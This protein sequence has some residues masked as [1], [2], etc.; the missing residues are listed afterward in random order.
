MAYRETGR[1]T[2]AIPLF[3]QTLADCERLFGA[4]HPRTL[5]VRKGL[6]RAQESAGRAEPD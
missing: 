1:V 2:E 4:D 3:E 6:A 5:L